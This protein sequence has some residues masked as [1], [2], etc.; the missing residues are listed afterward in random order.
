MCAI[1]QGAIRS[2][3]IATTTRAHGSQKL[4]IGETFAPEPERVDWEGV[5][6]ESR[7]LFV[8]E[9]TL[10]SVIDFAGLKG[11]YPKISHARVN[12]TAGSTC[13]SLL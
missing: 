6:E 7:R 2:C 8:W 1:Y 9:S 12:V 10:F 11:F 13:F 4:P 5:F 3:I